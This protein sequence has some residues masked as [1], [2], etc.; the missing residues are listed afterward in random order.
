[1]SL[2][3][4]YAWT[5]FDLCIAG[6]AKVR[7]SITISGGQLLIFKTTFYVLTI[8]ATLWL[9]TIGGLL[10]SLHSFSTG[11]G[12]AGSVAD[13]SIYIMALALSVL[14]QLAIIVPGLLL[15][16]PGRLWNVTRAERNAV[17]P[18][19]RFRGQTTILLHNI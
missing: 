2:H 14:M 18:R 15:L 9:L 12:E 5:P 1:V 4:L 8:V 7:G 6:A 16:Q 19:Q 11:S 13:G 10:F 17:T 3:L